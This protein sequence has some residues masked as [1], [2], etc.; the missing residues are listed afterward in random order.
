MASEIGVQTIQ[1]TNGTDAM[2][3]DSSGRVGLSS[4]VAFFVRSGNSSTTSGSVITSWSTPE[5]NEG[6]GFSTSTGRFTAPVAGLYVFSF[7]ILADADSTQTNIYLR[8]NGSNYVKARE[9]TQNN[10]YQTISGTAVMS[11]SVNEYADLQVV[12]N[13]LGGHNNE[14]QHFTGFLLG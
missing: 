4:P 13:N 1:H 12:G 3:I 9:D 6:N 5:V 11:L 7:T 14:W 10:R 2:T 8:K